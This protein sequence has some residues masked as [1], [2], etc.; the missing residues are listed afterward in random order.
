MNLRDRRT[1][2]VFNLPV[3]PEFGDGGSIFSI[4]P[5]GKVV[6][7]RAVIEDEFEGGGSVMIFWDGKT[8][9]VV[10]TDPWLLEPT[11]LKSP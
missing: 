10:R 3:L 7:A 6:M 2:T 9:K 1:G 4:A 8:Q 5:N 11:S